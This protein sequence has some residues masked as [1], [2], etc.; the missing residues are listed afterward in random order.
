[1]MRM[2]PSLPNPVT[3]SVRIALRLLIVFGSY[4]ILVLLEGYLPVTFPMYF[5]SLFADC[6]F[7]WFPFGGYF[8]VLRRAPILQSVSRAKRILALTGIC[9]V[10]TLL[11]SIMMGMLLFI[12]PR[13]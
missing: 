12:L 2:Q 13:Y 4:L 7:F 9:L 3:M 8:L 6:L 1:M 10:L 11:S 5:K